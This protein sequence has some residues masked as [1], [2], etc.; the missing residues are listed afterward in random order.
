MNLK[1]KRVLVMGLGI[2][3][4]STIKALDELGA[5]I[6]INDIKTEEELKDILGKIKDIS[7]EK[8]LGKKSLDLS[9]IELIVKSPGIPPSNQIL[10]DAV[11]KDIKIINDIELGSN[12]SKSKNI[13]AITGT[14][15][16]TTATTLTGEIF[17][18]DNKNPFIG[19][20]IGK[21]LIKDMINA[22]KNDIFIL[23]TS[24]FQLEHTI[25]FKPKVSLIL[26]ITSDHIDWHGTFKKYI[27]SKK[28][29]FI[30]QDSN[31]YTILNYDD[32]L[33]RTFK[34][35]INSNIIWFSVDEKLNRGIYIEDE[36]III[37]IDG[38]KKNL[39]PI[40]K[41]LLKGKHNLENILGSIAISFIMGVSVENIKRTLLSFKG[42]E[43]R[44]EFVLEK[45]GRKF[46]NDSKGTN[47]DSSIKAIE[48]IEAPIILIAGG[49]DKRVEF[50]EFIKSFNGK[51]KALVLL[52]DT[53][54]KIKETALKYGFKENFLVNSMEE[55]VDLAY[56]LSKKGDNILLSPACASWG[57]FENFEERGRVFK[58]KVDVLGEE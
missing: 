50:D 36:T 24:S 14:N 46:F 33:L 19:G 22:Q 17:K 11:D 15:G 53:S 51:V 52:G 5:K 26:N 44:L 30:N 23:E 3:G 42:V 39:I 35:E 57:M 45:D 56:S 7:L 43:H 38:E 1:D 12:L 6:I 29:I 20:N 32:K 54:S 9:G 16:K 31:D 27:K 25:N 58:H 34:D 48:A 4:I 49:Y 40:N 13:I 21:S 47:I 8:Y 28:K 2:S 55:A 10:L 41:L 18:A 37:N